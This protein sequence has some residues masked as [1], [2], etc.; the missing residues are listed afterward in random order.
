MSLSIQICLNAT[1]STSAVTFI[2]ITTKTVDF[3]NIE[4]YQNRV[5]RLSVDGFGFWF[6]KRRGSN[7]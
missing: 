7:V 4:P 6:L 1:L 5:F 2:E 3:I